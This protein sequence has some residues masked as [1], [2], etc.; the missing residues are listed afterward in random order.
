VRDPNQSRSASK[1]SC[2]IK[3]YKKHAARE[4]KKK[5]AAREFKKKHAAQGLFQKK[6]DRSSMLSTL[7]LYIFIALTALTFAR[8]HSK[9]PQITCQLPTGC[10]GCAGNQECKIFSDGSDTCP[11]AKCEPYEGCLNCLQE[12]PECGNCGEGERC[13]IMPQT[14]FSCA[15]AI[16]V[17]NDELC[18]IC[19]EPQGTCDSCAVGKVCVIESTGPCDC[20]EPKCVTPP[21]LSNN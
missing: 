11:Y 1:N 13:E 12:L 20:P 15:R 19:P 6:N 9:S 16:C 21:D 7:K 10:T 18:A 17:S 5:H 3:I 2:V 14:C 8:K 4:Y